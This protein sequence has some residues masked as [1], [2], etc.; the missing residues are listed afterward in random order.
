MRRF[1]RTK[2]RVA[3]VA[4]AL[5]AVA[6]LVAACVNGSAPGVAR[7][8]STTTKTSPSSSAQTTKDEKAYVDGVKY[9]QCMR[10][11]S[12]PNFPDPNSQG[13]FVS[14]HGV[15]NGQKVDFNSSHYV[16]ANKVC[17][18]L[19]PNGGQATPAE[20]EALVAQALK[21]VHCL[22]AHGIPNMPDPTSS[23]GNVGISFAHTEL[24]PDSPRLQAAMKTCQSLA[25]GG[26]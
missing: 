10:T 1:R 20:M 17:E 4:L 16:S 22:R 6:V 21:Y 18:H 5:G 8:G 9:A 12:V 7:L 3:A 14:I 2:L 15:L 24:S 26:S 11:H 25:L 13:Q 23:N 19:L